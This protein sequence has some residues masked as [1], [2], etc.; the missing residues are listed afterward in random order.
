MDAIRTSAA[1]GRRPLRE[2]RKAPPRRLVFNANGVTYAAYRDP[3]L[4]LRMTGVKRGST[5]PIPIPNSV[6]IPA[7]A[8]PS[9]ALPRSRSSIPDPDLRS[10]IPPPIDSTAG[11]SKCHNFLYSLV[12]YPSAL[13]SS[14]GIQSG[15]CSMISVISS[16]AVPSLHST[17]TSS[18]TWPQM[19]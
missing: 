7:P 10:P 11:H 12:S 16:T 6:P 18:W 3:S 19:K 13:S 15:V 1:N 5:I 8:A 9:G 2:Y 14:P 17:M 4:S